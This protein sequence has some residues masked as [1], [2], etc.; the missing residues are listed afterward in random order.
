M[1]SFLLNLHFRIFRLLFVK[2]KK[3]NM[4]QSCFAAQQETERDRRWSSELRSEWREGA[5]AFSCVAVVCLCVWLS[6]FHVQS[7]TA[8]R[9]MKAQANRGYYVA[10]L[11]SETYERIW[12]HGKKFQK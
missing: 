3:K 9:D 4:I 10:A 11:S 6:H 12:S 5:N 8:R 7:D 2:K 1:I